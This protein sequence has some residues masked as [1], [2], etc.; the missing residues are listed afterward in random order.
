ML[1]KH[2]PKIA[3]AFRD[4]V[5]TGARTVPV[6]ALSRAIETGDI[7]LIRAL[8]RLD[9]SFA[10]EEAVRAAFV[11]GGR[12]VETIAPLAA[13]FAFNGKHAA[14]EQWI[15]ANGA[16]LV[17]G[18]RDEAVEVARDVILEG[19]REGHGSA[20]VARELIGRGRARDGARIGLTLEQSRAV[21]NT[22]KNLQELDGN[23]FKR[24]WRDKRYD[25]Q[26]RRAIK[27]GKP[28]SASQIDTIT[29]RYAER[30]ERY[31]ARLIAQQESRRS[32]QGGQD[33]AYRQLMDRPNVESVT[34]KWQWNLGAQQD[35]REDHQEMS[36]TILRNDEPFVFPDGA[37]LMYPNDPAA[38]VKHTMWCHCTVFRRVNVRAA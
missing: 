35:P 18:I 33:Q 26:V 8:L 5:R 12:S 34:K 22:R 25:A 19:I 16:R 10:L 11:D 3:Q 23:Y 17:Q 36:G 14:A 29:G 13:E 15:A 4:A 2:G 7:D 31:R 6:P 9:Q 20:K 37:R 24:A 30:A 21:D 27:D 38:P 28:L 32:I 1:K